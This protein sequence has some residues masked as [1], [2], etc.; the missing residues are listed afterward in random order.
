[1]SQDNKQG[2]RLRDA[3]T[4]R[5]SRLKFP[6]LLALVGLLFVVNVV[7]PDFIPLIDEIILGLMTAAL[8]MMRESRQAPS[9][10]E[11]KPQTN[12][13]EGESTPGGE[14]AGGAG[15]ASR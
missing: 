15:G 10:D 4:Q 14:D 8:A 7:V 11:A 9:A 2:T 6:K 3:A 13:I 5:G 12:V 1:M